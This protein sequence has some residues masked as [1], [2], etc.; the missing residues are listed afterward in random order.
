MAKIESVEQ[1]FEAHPKWKN[2]LLKLKE[3][4]HSSGL[5]EGIKWGSPVYMKDGKNLVGIGAFKNHFGLWFFQGALLKEN[6]KLLVNAQEGKTQAIRQIKLDE[7]SEID[8][9][10]LKKYIDETIFLHDQGKT[11][12]LASPQKVEIPDELKK[13]LDTDSELKKAFSLLSPGKQ[14]EYSLYIIEAKREPT[15]Q[16]RMQKII[17]M[18]MEGIGLNDKYNDC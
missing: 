10:L 3:L 15:K 2:Q 12:K 5:T 8:L 4:L 16:K 17:P 11:V 18:I 6:T 7:T 9:D 14:K 13:E 1:Y